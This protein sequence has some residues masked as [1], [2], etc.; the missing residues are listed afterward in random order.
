[1]K[2]YKHKKLASKKT[3]EKVSPETNNNMM[4]QYK[5]DEKVHIYQDRVQ[6]AGLLISRD[7]HCSQVF[8]P[9]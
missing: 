1:M 5:P 2:Q 3:Q 8:V 6:G 7:I 4:K 9:H